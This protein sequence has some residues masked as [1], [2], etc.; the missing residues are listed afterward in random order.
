MEKKINLIISSRYR[1]CKVTQSAMISETFPFILRGGG[2]D[3]KETDTMKS[4]ISGTEC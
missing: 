3:R 2:K 4:Q 1:F